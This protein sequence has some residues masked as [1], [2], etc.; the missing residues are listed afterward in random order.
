MQVYRNMV[1]RIPSSDIIRPDSDASISILPSIGK[2]M[3]DIL[4]P[5]SDLSEGQ[6]TLRHVSGPGHRSGVIEMPL[7][8]VWSW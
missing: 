6:I 3:D 2:S 5:L 1:P 8:A 4:G 7:I